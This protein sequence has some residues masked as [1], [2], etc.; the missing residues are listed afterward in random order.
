MIQTAVARYLSQEERGK[1]LLS[2]GCSVK[3]GFSCFGLNRIAKGRAIM[4]KVMP[5][6][7][8]SRRT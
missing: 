7:E 5:R 6:G 1:G 8:K 3:L 2:A 4:A